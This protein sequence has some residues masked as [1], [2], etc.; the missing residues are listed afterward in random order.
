MAFTSLSW[1]CDTGFAIRQ[2]L[3]DP[4]EARAVMTVSVGGQSGSWQFSS[5][6]LIRVVSGRCRQS[7]T[8][9]FI[10]RMAVPS[11]R[12]LSNIPGMLGLLAQG[13]PQDVAPG[14]ANQ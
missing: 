14:I 13:H 7:V 4:S 6:T 8:S 10:L 9:D 1:I 11:G 5:I 2:S 3:V 12:F